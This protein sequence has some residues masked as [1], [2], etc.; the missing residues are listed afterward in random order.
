MLHL[1]VGVAEEVANDLG[2]VLAEQGRRRDIRK[3]QPLDVVGQRSIPAL[4]VEFG[5]VAG[6]GAGLLLDLG[7]W[8]GSG[9]Y[10]ELARIAPRANPQLS[11][12][13]PQSIL[14][15]YLFMQPFRIALCQLRAHDI[16]RA[17]ENLQA[18]LEALD[19]AGEAGAQLVVLPECSYPAYYLRDNS[20][21]ERAEVRDY[22]EFLS[23]LSHAAERH[24]YW[25]A[26]GVAR[27]TDSGELRNSA[28]MFGPDGEPR[29]NYDKSFLWHFDNEWFQRGREF[30]VFDAGFCRF[31]VLICAD[32][33]QPEVAR[34]LTVAGAEVILDLTAWV[35]WGRT[36]AE[37]STTQCEYL[38]PTRAF[39]NGVWVAAADKWG[40]EAGTIVYAGRSC[41]IDP[42]GVTR[43]CAASQGKHMKNMI[44][45]LAVAIAL[46]LAT[47]TPT[48]AQDGKEQRFGLVVGNSEYAAGAL[49]TT[50]N[51]AGLIAQTLQAAGFD[52]MGARDLDGEAHTRL[53]RLVAPPREL[54]DPRQRRRRPGRRRLL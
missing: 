40:Q 42:E 19:D 35:S 4:R 41:V 14:P 18:I 16:E 21:W 44:Y 24:G 6:D 13:N 38:M 11:I 49:P 50:A 8:N 36:P 48:L 43:V 3:V 1:F 23:L 31:G 15:Y 45:G 29:G 54:P 2:G 32:G 26:A 12:R 51:D 10:A 28:M 52:V 7:N 53:R 34:M 46:S 25:L 39:E 37:L 22:F 9:K 5:F 20:P 30:P 27:C 33:R 17:E 47:L